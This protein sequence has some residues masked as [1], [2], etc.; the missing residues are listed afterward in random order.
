MNDVKFWNN[1]G[2]QCIVC[3]SCIL[4]GGWSLMRSISM[5]EIKCCSPMRKGMVKTMGPITMVVLGWFTMP[6]ILLTLI[7]RCLDHL[8]QATWLERTQTILSV[9]VL[10]HK[11][12]LAIFL[13]PLRGEGRFC[14]VVGVCLFLSN[15]LPPSSVP[16]K[17]TGPTWWKRKQ[18]WEVD[19]KGAIFGMTGLGFRLGLNRHLG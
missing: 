18:R 14:K 3:M 8:Y 10:A 1:F 4:S 2:L 15:P 13:P 19:K 16:Q 9:L 12:G 17:V 6:V 5:K 11:A 7:Y